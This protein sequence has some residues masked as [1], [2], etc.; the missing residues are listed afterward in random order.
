MVALVRNDKLASSVDANSA[1]TVKS[2]STSG[3]INKARRSRAGKSAYAA[4]G[5][6]SANRVTLKLCHKDDAKGKST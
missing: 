1:R 4:I 6:D 3:C 5:F 2:R